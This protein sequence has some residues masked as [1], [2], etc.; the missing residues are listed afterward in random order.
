M[1]TRV[2]VLLLLALGVSSIAVA[3]EPKA[4]LVVVEKGKRTL[5]ILSGNRVV[6]TYSV[7]LGPNPQGHK[8]Q[9]GDGRTP[10]GR[11]TIDYKNE[12]SAY[13]LA[14]HISYPNERDVLEARRRGV[15]PGGDI[16]LHGL[17][18]GVGAVGQGED[19]TRGCI[20]VNN[21]EIEEIARMVP[22]G[23]PIE[24]RP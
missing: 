14:L 4:D 18:N 15:S 1:S 3:N 19:W 13:Y 12:K 24:I 23:T 5:S 22:N 17:P 2:T 7:A 20:A 6:K 21:E 10:E 8:L 11:Y 9:V 16:M